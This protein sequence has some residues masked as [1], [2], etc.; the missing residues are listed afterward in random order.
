MPGWS[1]R[2]LLRALL[3][4]LCI[5][6][7]PAGSLV[8]NQADSLVV[9]NVTNATSHYSNGPRLAPMNIEFEYKVESLL[10]ALLPYLTT[11]P[12]HYRETP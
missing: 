7:V 9:F 1:D 12:S 5:I 10:F 3:C 2:G 11:D 4:V 6:R 8:V